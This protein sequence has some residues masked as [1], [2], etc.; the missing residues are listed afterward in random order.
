MRLINIILLGTTIC[1][2]ASCKDDEKEGCTDPISVSYDPEAKKDDGSCAYAGQGGMTELVLFPQFNNHA[3]VSTLSYPDTAYIKFNAVTFPGYAASAWDMVIP[4]NDGENHLHAFNM[5]KGKYFVYVTGWDV[6][7]NKRVAGGM[8][9]TI[10]QESGVLNVNVATVE[11][12][13]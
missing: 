6:S 13:Q 8:P 5:K 2:L 11:S 4:G 3:V 1:F 10:S 7:V 12:T 9:I